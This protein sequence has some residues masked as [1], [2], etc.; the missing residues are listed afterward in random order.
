MGGELNNVVK[1]FNGT[2]KHLIE[3][4]NS[5]VK[6]SLVKGVIATLNVQPEDIV[7]PIEQ[8]A[9][10]YLRPYLTFLY[11]VPRRRSYNCL[12]I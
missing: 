12:I 10:I 5:G 2:L 8:I 11:W 7:K 6:Y 9:K 3:S 4:F 1:V